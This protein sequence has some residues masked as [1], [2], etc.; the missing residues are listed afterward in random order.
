MLSRKRRRDE[1][2]EDREGR[3]GG[4]TVPSPPFAVFARLFRYA[5]YATVQSP[6]FASFHDKCAKEENE[7]PKDELERAGSAEPADTESEWAGSE[8]ATRRSSPDAP[9]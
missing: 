5:C 9:S 8:P 1:S 7:C 6:Y 4:K 3:E 2:R